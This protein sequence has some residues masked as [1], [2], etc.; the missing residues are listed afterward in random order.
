[1]DNWQR[2]VCA[3]FCPGNENILRD[4]REQLPKKRY[5]KT[6]LEKK[7]DYNNYKKREKSQMKKV[8]N[9]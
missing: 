5:R 3:T 6:A 1:L 4:L 9:S 7:Q 2:G 8:E